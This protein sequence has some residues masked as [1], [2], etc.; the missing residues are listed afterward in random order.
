[1]MQ[2]CKFLTAPKSASHGTPED[3]YRYA[4]FVSTNRWHITPISIISLTTP[5]RVAAR[6]TAPE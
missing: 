2:T 5:V 6:T 3:D 1:M 4:P